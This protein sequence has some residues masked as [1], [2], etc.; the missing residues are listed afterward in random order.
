MKKLILITLFSFNIL[1][2]YALA[3]NV[4]LVDRSEELVIGEKFIEPKSIS[5][6]RGN[7]KSID[8]KSL[9][10]KVV[11]L[12]FFDTFCGTCIN[13]MP[14][15][16]ELQ[17]KYADKLQIISITWQDKQT[18]EQFFA[19]N[20]YLK[21]HSVN[22]PVIYADKQLASFF[23]H[24]GKPHVVML[25]KGIVKAITF[26]RSITEENINALYDNGNI[27]LPLKNDFGHANLQ[28]SSDD[29]I[30]AG[31][32]IS[33]YQNG[34]PVQA[35]KIEQDSITGKYKSSV[36][37]RSIYRSLL[38]SW[39]FIKVPTYVLLP[40]RVIWKVRD[41]SIF[42]DFKREGEVWYRKFGI[43]Y[44]RIDQKG[45]SD[46]EQAQVVLDDL[47]NFFGL[48]TYYTTKEMNS[49]VLESCPKKDNLDLKINNKRVYEGSIGLATSL[50][51]KGVFPPA[52]D[53]VKLNEN[54]GIGD[55]SNLEELNKQLETYG[56]R[57]KFGRRTL[58]VF[59]IE[60]I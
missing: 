7:I 30:I 16:Q 3:Q 13:F 56:I 22:L 45:R 37:N 52:V 28:T 17:N 29:N 46:A 24:K 14:K 31:T 23:P 47:H 34:V 10:N 44:E 18:M 21:E 2:S 5:M 1:F 49:L 12:D 4:N 41:S 43:C 55:Y 36:Y 25:Y 8:W 54:I 20:I 51:F 32:W 26:H 9:E 59:V 39:S 50:D 53:E 38:N 58:E 40:S 42:D 48:K 11:I 33:G 19:K 57:A 60:E 35:L 27:D 6:M 15:L